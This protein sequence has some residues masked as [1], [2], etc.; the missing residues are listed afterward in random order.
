MGCHRVAAAPA[1]VN[2]TAEWA[3]RADSAFAC[4]YQRAKERP[5][6]SADS[7]GFFTPAAS[8]AAREKTAF[9]LRQGGTRVGILQ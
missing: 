6:I 4:R 7:A 9:D 5:M 3:R 2:L 1:R 8:V